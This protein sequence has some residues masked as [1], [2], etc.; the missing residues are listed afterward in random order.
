M[1]CEVIETAQLW[2][3]GDPMTTV[4]STTSDQL[5]AVLR[6]NGAFSFAS[7][8]ASLALFIPL[9]SVFD[10]PR[11]ALILVGVGLVAYAPMLFQFAKAQRLRRWHAVIPTVG[12]ELWVAASVLVA[13][14]GLGGVSVAGRLIL[15]A[16]CLPVGRF[17][18]RQWSLGQRL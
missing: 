11:A 3:H 14:T 7:G 18:L 6:Q 1:T 8:V 13:A 9:A 16:T 17:A 10:V 2:M 12:D 15:L 5:R 4:T